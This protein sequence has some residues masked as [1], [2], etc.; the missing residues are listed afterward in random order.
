MNDEPML[1]ILQNMI[2]IMECDNI[3]INNETH[4]VNILFDK[5]SKIFVNLIIKDNSLHELKNDFLTDHVIRLLKFNNLLQLNEE[6]IFD[7]VQFVNDHVKILTY[8]TI[9]S[10]KMTNNLHKKD[11]TVIFCNK[12]ETKYMK[13]VTENTIT[14]L[15]KNDKIVL[16]MLILTAYACFKHPKRNDI[17]KPFPSFFESFESLEKKV[18]YS[19]ENFGKLLN[20]ISDCSDDYELFDKIGVND[21]SFL[22]YI[23]LTNITDLKSDILFAQETKNIFE[24]KIIMNIFEQHE[25]LTLQVRH[26]PLIDYKFNSDNP[27]YLF[28]G[29]TL[30]N[31]YSILRNGIKNFSRSHLMMNGAAHGNG[32][33]LSDSLAVSHSYGGDRFCASNLYVIGVVQVLNDKKTYF[34]VPGIYVVPNDDEIVLRYIII[35]NDSARNLTFITKYFMEQRQYEVSRSCSSFINIRLKRILYDSD[36]IN[37]LGKKYEW[38]SELTDDGKILIKSNDTYVTICITYFKDYPSS[39]PF[40]WVTETQ[41]KFIDIHV[42][43]KGGIIYK[44]LNNLEWKPSIKI[45]KIIKNIMGSISSEK[46][47]KIVHSEKDAYENYL[48]MYAKKT[49]KQIL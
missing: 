11:N 36:K 2:N 12:C 10:D 20:V 41:K 8:C 16:N 18:K 15:Y 24:Q 46:I 29:S 47:D 17:F 22:K 1:N 27:Q 42:M 35:L 25:V 48:S 37:K 9:C 4:E 21:Y 32:V 7:F 14:E 6:N 45:H 30:S 31:W 43:E 3:V 40:I 28:H 34:K 38:T 13:L 33:Y 5:S 39:S 23:I 26:N 44:K 49:E 19:Y